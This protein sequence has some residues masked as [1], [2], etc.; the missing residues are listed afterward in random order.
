MHVVEQLLET[1]L[2]V[3]RVLSII[4]LVEN[5]NLVPDRS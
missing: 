1:E 2:S 5:R 4:R 3:P